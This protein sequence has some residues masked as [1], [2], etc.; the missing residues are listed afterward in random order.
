MCVCNPY[1]VHLGS[2]VSAVGTSDSL[3]QQEPS[4]A[5]CLRACLQGVHLPCGGSISQAVGISFTMLPRTSL[6]HWLCSHFFLTEFALLSHQSFSPVFLTIHML[7]L[8]ITDAI[9]LGS[10]SSA[11]VYTIPRVSREPAVSSR[12]ILISVSAHHSTSSQYH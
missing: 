9:F 3:S 2:L 10:C 11:P 1:P 4:R 8:G 7:F 12:H 6:S 5:C